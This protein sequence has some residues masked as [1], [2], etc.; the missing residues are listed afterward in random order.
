MSD[1][2]RRDAPA[3]QR[4]RQLEAVIE[5]GL[6]IIAIAIL[7]VMVALVFVAVVAR[8]AFNSPLI[9]SYDLSTLLFA[10]VVFLGLYVAERDGAHIGLDLVQNMAHGPMRTVLQL[11]KQ[12]LLIA[13]AAFLTWIG[14]RLIQRTGMQIPSM[15]ISA[16]WLYASLPVGFAALTLIYVLR[17]PRIIFS[18]ED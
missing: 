9:Y 6:S 13:L 18:R 2:T 11:V 17:L 8:Y 16:K 7:V 14:Y 4:L 15:R 5:W 3:M 10:W 1:I 12:G